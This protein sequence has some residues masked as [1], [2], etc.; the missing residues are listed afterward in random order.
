MPNLAK[1]LE[2]RLPGDLFQLLRIASQLASARDWGLYL[3]GGVV[4]DLLLG[5]PNLDIDLVVEGDAV[6]LARELAGSGGELTSHPAFSTAKVK[7][8]NFAMDLAMAR[9]ETYARP[10]ALPQVSPGNIV[11]DL[12]RRDFTINAMA[13]RLAP[14]PF[15][16]AIDPYCGKADLEQGLVRILHPR[17]F[18]DDPTRMFRAVRYEQRLGFHLETETERLLRR[19]IAW[20]SQ[21]S[22]DRLRHEL[23]LILK[24]KTPERALARAGELGLLGALHPTLRADVW[25]SQKF[26]ETRQEAG[27]FPDPDLYLALMVY[28]FTNEELEDF[29]SRLNIPGQAAR[30]LRDALKTKER[31]PALS[32]PELPPSA[33]YRQL[34]GLLPQAIQV[35]ALASDNPLLRQR[36]IL[37][38]EKLRHIKPALNGEALIRLGVSPGPRL[39]ELLRALQD[40]RLDGKVRT[41]DEEAALVRQWLAASS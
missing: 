20:L 17:S 37:Y 4:R 40:A 36:L 26:Q 10:G 8:G 14:E 34:E 9:A 32:E 41:A 27:G 39:G 33:L 5:R 38:I 3:V 23:E 31:L 13:I 28:S 16:E 30:I 22:G 35:C 12:F 29:I 2:A 18:I 25:L 19:D 11:E 21:I 15:G 1:Q 6:Y 7:W 24:E